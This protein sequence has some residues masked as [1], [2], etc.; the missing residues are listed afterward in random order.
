MLR[1]KD[2]ILQKLGNENVL[3][4]T[5]MEVTSLN[6]ILVLNDTAL[7]I[8][9]M[10]ENDTEEKDLAEALV[11]EYGID[12]SEARGDITEFLRELSSKNMLV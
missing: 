6:G 1:K 12:E 7:F 11:K 2:Y 4:P 10:L 8:W 9:Q 5:G 3:I